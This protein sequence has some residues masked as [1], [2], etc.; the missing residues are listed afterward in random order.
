ME[1]QTPN[2]IAPIIKVSRIPQSKNRL[3]PTKKT[4][5]II[6]APRTLKNIKPNAMTPIAKL[7]NMHFFIPS[8]APSAKGDF[9]IGK[10]IQ[11][12][13]AKTE[14]ITTNEITHAKTPANVMLN[15]N[16]LV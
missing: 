4:T 10:Y 16:F 7:N 14:F 12:E 2:W 1:T 5:S 11:R 6:S 15:S 8:A 9:S 3:I 13:R